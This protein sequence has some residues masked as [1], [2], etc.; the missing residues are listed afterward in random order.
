[1]SNPRNLISINKHIEYNLIMN[2]ILTN[3]KRG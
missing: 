1:M 2:N 3:S